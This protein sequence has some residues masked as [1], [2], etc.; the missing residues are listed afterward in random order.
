MYNNCNVYT[1][2]DQRSKP[3]NRGIF[4]WDKSRSFCAFTGDEVPF[5]PDVVPDQRR[6]VQDVPVVVARVK[7]ERFDLAGVI[8]V[9]WRFRRSNRIALRNRKRPR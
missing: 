4:L 1:T 8:A 3:R 6:E 2:S 5:V 9:A 7:R